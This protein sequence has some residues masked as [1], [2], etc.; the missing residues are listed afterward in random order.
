MASNVWT[1]E[2]A[3]LLE[4]LAGYHRVETITQR[5]NRV[6]TK[7]GRPRRTVGAVQSKFDRMKLSRRCI[8][9]NFPR[10]ELVNI[11]GV[12]RTRAK[13]WTEAY[14]LPSKKGKALITVKVNQFRE[15]AY[16]NPHHLAGIEADRLDWLM[17]DLE[18][19]EKVEAMPR[20]TI[21]IKQPVVRCSDG[22]VFQSI[23]A[24]ARE[25]FVTSSS[26]RKALRVSGAKCLGS[27]WRYASKDLRCG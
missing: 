15:W 3:G 5:L 7:A 19:C 12:P 4:A 21:G 17:D 13:R 9:D 8:L 23:K 14:G 22:K 20:S 16:A 24:A 2:E 26:L 11:L 10:D 6:N 27:E 1:D 18:F 25:N